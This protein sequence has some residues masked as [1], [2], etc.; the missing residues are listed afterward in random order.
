LA[1]LHHLLPP[2]LSQHLPP[3]DLPPDREALL[4]ALSSGQL[5]CVAYNVGI[6]R[7]KKP[8]GYINKTAIHDIAALEAENR[9][10][11]A[12]EQASGKKRTWTFRRTENLR[13]WAACVPAAPQLSTTHHIT[14]SALKLRY[15]L[16][17]ISSSQ[18][19]GTS[20]QTNTPLPSPSVA[21]I[22]FHQVAPPTLFDA[23]TVAKREEH[24]E[25]MLE[26]AL[27]KWVEAVVNEKRAE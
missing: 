11:A 1:V 21:T 13:L 18:L 9:T 24:W 15:M 23:P 5:L 3:A 17:L 7:S 26:A 19:N 8:W 16:P 25:D 22:A 6:R 10:K 12:Q 4:L 27:F 2:E 20:S 14:R